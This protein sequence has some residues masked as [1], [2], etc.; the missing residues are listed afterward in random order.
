MIVLEVGRLL[1]QRLLE[2]AQIAEGTGH[3]LPQRHAVGEAAVLIHQRHA[4]SGHARHRPAG[5]QE[6]AG[7]QADQRGFAGAV[8]AD[9]GPAVARADGQR[10]VPKDLGR[11][12]I[13]PRVP[14]RDKRHAGAGRRCAITVIRESNQTSTRREALRPRARSR[15]GA[16]PANAAPATRARAHAIHHAMPQPRRPR[17]EAG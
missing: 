3:D 15:P 4:Q 7:D 9:Y 10:D 14:D 5:G 2:R 11:A 8:P 12:E 17:W 16:R 13:H 1:G 6:I